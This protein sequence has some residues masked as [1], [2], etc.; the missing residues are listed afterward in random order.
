[1][2]PCAPRPRATNDAHA[3][4]DPAATNLGIMRRLTKRLQHCAIQHKHPATFFLDFLRNTPSPGVRA[5]PE[6][7]FF[8]MR[9]AGS[10]VMSSPATL[11]LSPTGEMPQI[12][13]GT[14]GLKSKDVDATLRHAVDVGYRLFDLHVQSALEPGLSAPLRTCWWTRRKNNWCARV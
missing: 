12:G 6:W 1:M 10:S 5:Q 14:W 11:S 7:I 8:A 9:L 2:S 13:F 3:P 4:T